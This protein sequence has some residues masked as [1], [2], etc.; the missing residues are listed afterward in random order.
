ML[1]SSEDHLGVVQA[2]VWCKASPVRESRIYAIQMAEFPFIKIGSSNSVPGRLRNL[3][4]SS[5]FPYRLLA[6]ISAGEDVEKAIHAA[7]Q[8]ERE[9][10]EWFRY[11]GKTKALVDA[12]KQRDF[13][14]DLRNH[15]VTKRVQWM[16]PESAPFQEE[17]LAYL[18]GNRIF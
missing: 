14:I 18:V 7:L 12:M 16:K 17:V 5:P 3:Q 11:E 6:T 1:E 4:T 8:D 9:R 15:L 2:D 13:G 10:G